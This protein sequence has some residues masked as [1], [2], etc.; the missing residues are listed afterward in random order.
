ML[1]VSNTQKLNDV[2]QWT[3]EHMSL[4]KNIFEIKVIF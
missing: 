2:T 1:V 4:D 3:L